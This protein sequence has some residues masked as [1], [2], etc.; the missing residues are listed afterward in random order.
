MRV[1]G[2]LGAAKTDVRG[3][4]VHVAKAADGSAYFNGGVAPGAAA[5]DLVIADFGSSGILC[6]TV[7]EIPGLPPVLDPFGHI[8]VHVMQPVGVGGETI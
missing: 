7:R 8:A 5:N 4:L 1:G 6:G 2:V 3:A